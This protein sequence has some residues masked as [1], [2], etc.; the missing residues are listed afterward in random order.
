MLQ[1]KK[2]IIQFVGFKTDL[3]DQ[4][5]ITRWQPFATNFKNLGIKTIDLYK[6]ENSEKINY[7]SRNIWEEQ[8][9]FNTFPTGIGA[10]VSRGG[11]QVMQYGGYWIE[12]NDL[13]YKPSMKLIFSNQLKTENCIVRKRCA[14]KVPFEIQ[15]EIQTEND[16][17]IIFEPF[18]IS[19]HL[20]RM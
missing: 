3:Q 4:D 12:A 14:M 19:Q 6:V 5:F 15:A 10:S 17:N 1:E 16:T 7:I 18:F 9:Y 2:Y 8:D 11:I 13:E 20:K